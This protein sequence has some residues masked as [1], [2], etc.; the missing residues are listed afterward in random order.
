VDAG[1][2]LVDQSG[3]ALQDIVVSVRKVG[4]I[5]AEIAAASVEQTA[6]V[7][8]I[9]KAIAQL[10]SGTQQN[11]AMVEESAAASQ[12][13]NDQAVQLRQQVSVF[14]LGESRTASPAKKVSRPAKS[15]RKPSS[16]ASPKPAARRAANTP[17]PAA[18]KSTTPSFPK[19]GTVEDDDVWEEF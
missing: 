18:K 19:A 3:E 2:K 4:D 1:S 12:R 7:D 10:D 14:D 5:I 8:Q 16:A 6:G 11:T 13:L 9:N 17:K 15:T